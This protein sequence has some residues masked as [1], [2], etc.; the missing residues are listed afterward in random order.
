MTI[1]VL[2]YLLV[3][4]EAIAG[5]IHGFAVLATVLS[6]IGCFFLGVM[7][8]SMAEASENEEA[9]DKSWNHYIGRSYRKTLKWVVAIAIVGHLVSGIIPSQKNMAIIVGTS[10]AYMALT[11]EPA[12]VLGNKAFQ[13][14]EKKIDDALQSEDNGGQAEEKEESKGES[15]TKSGEQKS[16]GQVQQSGQ[17][18]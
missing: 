1:F 16:S 10:G 9:F 3:M 7:F 13:L 14:L 17:S 5:V 15:S 6:V 11:S 4:C 2:T 18:T 8:F 12:K